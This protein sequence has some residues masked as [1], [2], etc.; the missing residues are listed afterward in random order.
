M[1]GL[2][3]ATLLLAFRFDGRFHDVYC[4]DSMFIDIS[5]LAFSSFIF[6]FISVNVRRALV[7]SA[8]THAIAT[9]TTVDLRENYEEHEARDVNLCE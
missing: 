8:L 9:V 6:V 7:A 4:D 5:N 1:P 3:R 2:S